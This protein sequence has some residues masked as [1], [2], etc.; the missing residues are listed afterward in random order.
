MQMEYLD[1]Q[2]HKAIPTLISASRKQSSMSL[3]QFS[4]KTQMYLISEN[5]QIPCTDIQT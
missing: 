2:D 3:C 4:K 1:S 5:N